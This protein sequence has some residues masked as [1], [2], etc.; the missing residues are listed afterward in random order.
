MALFADKMRWFS[1]PRPEYEAGSG[2][3]VNRELTPEER[4]ELRRM[5]EGLQFA[6]PHAGGF[7]ALPV[8]MA[9]SE[10]GKEEDDTL[11]AYQQQ[12][13]DAQLA[14]IKSAMSA[15][16]DARQN[17]GKMSTGIGI[18]LGFER[19]FYDTASDRARTAMAL[20][21]LKKAGADVAPPSTVKEINKTQGT[22][23]DFIKML[24]SPR[25]ADIDA[26]KL[27]LPETL[28]LDEARRIR[29]LMQIMSGKG[30]F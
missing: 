7:A 2:R 22:V 12:I 21:I 26:L 11:K 1:A 9:R 28:N 3:L 10:F 20:E 14:S 19:P 18:G 30:G 6:Q 23:G 29:L 17:F 13:K 24:E 16:E 25:G 27:S 5:L 15:A 4:E 8:K